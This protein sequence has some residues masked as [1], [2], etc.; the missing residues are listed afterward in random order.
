AWTE[1]Q[2]YL[3]FKWSPEEEY[4]LTENVQRFFLIL[5][6]ILQAIIVFWFYLI[7][8][9]ALRVI[10]GSNAHDNRSDSESEN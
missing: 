9:V 4:Y 7:C 5:F 8:N 6:S 10:K 2:K 3:E 1:P